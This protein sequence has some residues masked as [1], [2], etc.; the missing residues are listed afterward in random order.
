MN[1]GF[2]SF[3]ATIVILLAVALGT[4]ELYGED[5]ITAE[6]EQ[7]LRVPII[8]MEGVLEEQGIEIKSK[9]DNKILEAAEEVVEVEERKPDRATNVASRGDVRG[10]KEVYTMEATAYT[11]TGNPTA[12]GIYPY[13]GV[14]AVD[15]NVIPLGSKLYIEG[16][17]FGLAADTGGAIKGDIVDVFMDTREEALQWGRRNVNVY[18][19]EK[20]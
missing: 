17:G 16:Y 3:L 2:K 19:M 4:A 15:P 9:D 5:A 20:P 1:I 8:L 18:L 7:E 14:V 13:V 12:T 11:H 10:A 6:L